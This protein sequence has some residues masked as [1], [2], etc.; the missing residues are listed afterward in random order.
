MKT[1]MAPASFGIILT[2]TLLG[3]YI[4][5]LLYA[6]NAQ[7]A[8]VLS[9]GEKGVRAVLTRMALKTSRAEK[10]ARM[11]TLNGEVV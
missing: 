5:V 9:M 7:A 10:T 6:S 3:A 11:V 2:Q 1:L 4:S 8:L